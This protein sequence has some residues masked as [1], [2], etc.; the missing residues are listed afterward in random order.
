M[1]TILKLFVLF[2]IGISLSSCTSRLIGTWTI[3]TYETTKPN[4][5]AVTLSNIGTI[6]FFK[7]GYG[8]K[9]VN[10]TVFGASY[11]DDLQFRW[12]TSDKFV[13][14]ESE[15]SEFSKTWI[16]IESTRRIQRWQSTNGGTQVEVLE[17]K[18]M[19]EP[20][21]QNM[22]KKSFFHRN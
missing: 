17:L 15:G 10:Y 12:S 5:Q 7:D 14:I 22:Q 20:T 6:T 1:K 11:N 18:K 9:R 4:Q 8:E 19:T 21:Q 2:L 16:M 3:Q 13:T